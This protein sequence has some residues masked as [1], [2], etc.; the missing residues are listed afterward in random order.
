M[1]FHLDEHIDSALAEAL[2][3]RQIDVTTTVEAGLQ[4]A[5]DLAHVD[6][7]RRAGRVI[8]TH[9]DDFLKLA[10]RGVE[11]G[12]I[13]YCHQQSRGIGEMIEFLVLIDACMNEQDMLNHVEFC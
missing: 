6:F 4:G 7:A 11:H 12:G 1:R 13:I 10:S 9:D 8:V 3:R 5:P 2:R